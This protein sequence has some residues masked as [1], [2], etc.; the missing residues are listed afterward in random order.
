MPTDTFLKKCHN[1][2]YLQLDKKIKK[3]SKMQRKKLSRKQSNK[4][5]KKGLSINKINNRSTTTRGGIRL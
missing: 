4:S 3:G 5:F 1:S 2:S